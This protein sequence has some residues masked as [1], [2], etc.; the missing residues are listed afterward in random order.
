MSNILENAKMKKFLNVCKK[1][2]LI[3]TTVA[4]VAFMVMLIVVSSLSH[5]RV[6]T[7]ELNILNQTAKA[8]IIFNE[9]SIEV[10]SYA[11]GILQT[12]NTSA[13]KIIDGKIYSIDENGKVELE[14]NI[15][16]YEFTFSE[17]TFKDTG[18]TQEQIAFYTSMKLTCKTNIAL[19]NVAISF[20]VIFGV[21]AIGCATILV[22]SKKGILKLDTNNSESE[23]VS[24]ANE[25]TDEMANQE[26]A[27][28]NENIANEEANNI[29]EEENK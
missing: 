27:Q 6:Y 21:C 15:N 19:R 24:V 23:N 1:Q 9:D 22:L 10:R 16:A 26:N 29:N 13:Y 11:N 25:T 17:E 14:G 5:G 18:M 7:Y 3:A 2:L 20:M 28:T 12:T 8:E 4:F